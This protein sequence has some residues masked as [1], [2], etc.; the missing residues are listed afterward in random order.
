MEPIHVLELNFPSI[1]DEGI[2]IGTWV[3]LWDEIPVKKIGPN[4]YEV[5]EDIP[6][7]EVKTL[8]EEMAEKAEKFRM[9]FSDISQEDMFHNFWHKD[10]EPTQKYRKT[11]KGTKR[12]QPW[13]SPRFF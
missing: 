2:P 8:E 6:V 13:E 11:S 3:I 4:L 12:I 9:T 7:I 10:L 1:K 5:Y